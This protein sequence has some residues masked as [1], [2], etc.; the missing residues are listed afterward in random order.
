MDTIRP[1]EVG[2]REFALKSST[3]ERVPLEQ[4]LAR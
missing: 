3:V 4:A 1:E 2:S